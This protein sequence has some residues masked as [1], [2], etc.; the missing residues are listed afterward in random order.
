MRGFYGKLPARGDFVRA[1]L[2]RRFTNAWDAW[3]Q[4]VLPAARARLGEARPG[5]AWSAAPSWCFALPPGVCGPDAALGLLLPSR[6]RA[7]RHF[8]L[9]FA[10][11]APSAAWA[12]G[13]AFLAAAARAGHAALE[14]GAPPDAVAKLLV[15]D[16]R[17]DAMPDFPPHA[18]LWW[19]GARRIALPGLPD[20]AGFAAMLGPAP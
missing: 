20:A 11:L 17:E 10:C 6:D 16:S 9:A 14:C 3:L 12:D 19:S 7:G 4:D 5:D 15:S 13:G 2:P 18:A 8:P 1:G